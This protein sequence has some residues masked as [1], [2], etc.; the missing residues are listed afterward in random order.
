MLLN[1]QVLIDRSRSKTCV[2]HQWFSNVVSWYTVAR[3]GR[4]TLSW[5]NEIS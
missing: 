2:N 4:E 5:Q 1:L 3:N